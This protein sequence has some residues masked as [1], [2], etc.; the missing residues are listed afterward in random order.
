MEEGKP[1]AVTN[2][3]GTGQ[4]PTYL[5]HYSFRDTD[6]YRQDQFFFFSSPGDRV[7]DPFSGDWEGILP[8]G[9]RIFRN[10][11]ITHDR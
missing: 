10:N 2:T 9:Y 7:Y 11:G 8:S 3:K 1:F 5:T 6:F 4:P